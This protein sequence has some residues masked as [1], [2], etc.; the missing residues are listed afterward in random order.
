MR[1]EQ[2]WKLNEQQAINDELKAKE[3]RQQDQR[4]DIERL[5]ER[6]TWQARVAAL[7]FPQYQLPKKAFKEAKDEHKKEEKDFARLQRQTEPNLLA[8]RGKDAYLKRNEQVVPKCANMAEKSENQ[9][10]NIK[11][12]IEAKKQQ[13]KELDGETAAAKKLSDKAKQ[14]MPGLQRNKTALE[15]AIE[16]RPADID[17]PAYNERLREVTR[18]IRDIDPR[19]EEIRLEIGSLSQHIK[20][21]AAIIE[22]AEAEKA[23]LN[24]QAGQQA[25]KLKRAS[26]EAHRAWEWIQKHPKRFQGEIY[27]P[28]IVSCSARDPRFA[29]QVES[30]LGQ[31]K[32]IAFTATSRDDYRELGK[33]VHDELRL[34]RINIRQSGTP[35]ANFRAPCTDE[36]LR[37]YGLK[38][39]I[40]DLIEGPEA[41]LAMLCDNRRIH[42]TG[43]TTR[44]QLGNAAVDALKGPQ[45][46]ITSWVTSTE[47]FQV[48]RRRESGEYATSMRANQLGQARYVIR[49]CQW[50][51]KVTRRGRLRLNERFVDWQ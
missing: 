39:W 35:L 43:Y 6:Q 38:G 49:G 44:D 25:K 34:D 12:A 51:R 27:G 4:G 40:L 29:R 11:T 8:E 22:Q 24:T 16:D 15:R 5:R 32:M 21:R 30:A 28:P 45:S 46:P 19:R 13:I 36:Q 26:P 1:K 37:S 9:A 31:G 50:G 33:V 2:K 17:F 20:Q 18:Q 10:S 48:L 23:S 41:V 3:D 7:P 14:D 42:A 47:S